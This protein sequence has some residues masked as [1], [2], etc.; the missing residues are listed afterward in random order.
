MKEKRLLLLLLLVFSAC[1]KENRTISI[2]DWNNQIISQ[3]NKTDSKIYKQEELK[4]NID[5]LL[6]FRKDIIIE[7]DKL[8]SKEKFSEF[9]FYEN[10]NCEF[11]PKDTIQTDIPFTKNKFYYS[12]L[13]VSNNENYLYEL[14]GFSEDKNFNI[15]K[16]YI[17]N[18]EDYIQFLDLE[19]IGIKKT[20]YLSNDF[21]VTSK[22]TC[23]GNDLNIEVISTRLN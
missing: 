3:L 5:F 17:Y 16:T 9:V 23:N 21:S 1:S 10:Y 14:K 22:I 6:E 2:D 13:I 8:K 19:N 11:N 7:I 15:I 20:N 12:I 4:I 18:K